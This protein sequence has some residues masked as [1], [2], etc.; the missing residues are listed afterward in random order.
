M[1]KSDGQ[2]SLLAIFAHP[3]DEAFGTG[4]LLA[5]NASR[6]SQTVLVTATRGE[7]GE[8]SDPTL[9]S[10]ENLGQ[11]REQE[12]R[13]AAKI[14]DLSELVILDY[15]DS[16]MV[17]T[18]DNQH[19]QA[20]AQADADEVIGQLVGVIRR[21][22]PDV[23][24]TFDEN[25][26]Y[27]HP[28]HIAIHDHAVAAYHAAGDSSRFSEQ[29]EPWN[30]ARLYYVVFPKSIFVRMRAML[31]ENGLDTSDLD[32]FEEHDLGWPDDKIHGV[33]DVSSVVES[34]WAALNSHKTQFGPDN[35]F[36]R[37]SVESAKSLMSREY[38]VQ[39]EPDPV[40]VGVDGQWFRDIGG[41]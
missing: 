19:P 33:V 32:R 4:G 35:L 1:N 11:V 40:T 2:H 12:L 7:V 3:D 5:L 26:G 27:G 30:P 17:G 38:L 24:L 18:E 28:D 9:A 31:E 25:G 10:Q 23:V 37:I 21:L 29:G 41:L 13:N 39:V 15:R 36:N 8:I 34:K 20:L 14:L 22:K 16:G 6:G